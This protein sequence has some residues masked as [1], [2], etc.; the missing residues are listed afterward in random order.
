MIQGDVMG[1]GL[2]FC[3]VVPSHAFDITPV[4]LDWVCCYIIGREALL[5]ERGHDSCCRVGKGKGGG[6]KR[7]TA[8]LLAP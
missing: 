1:G 4:C 5:V 6:G 2:F 7:I 3:N 8:N